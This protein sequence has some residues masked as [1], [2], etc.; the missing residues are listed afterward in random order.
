ML[1]DGTARCGGTGTYGQLGNGTATNTNWISGMVT[2]S[3][4][5]NATKIYT[6]SSGYSTNYG[7]SCAIL[8]DTTIKCWGYNGTG[9]LGDGTTSPKYAPI[10]TTGGTATGMSLAGASASSYNHACEV[11]TD[12]TVKCWGYNGLGQ[13]GDGTTTT[14][15]TPVTVSGITNAVKVYTAI[16]S[17]SSHGRSCALLS[18]TTVKCWGQLPGYGTANTPVT[19]TGLSGVV[20]FSMSQ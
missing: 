9:Q 6:A 7:M 3:G 10:K 12:G 15:P 20:D 18:D 5:T 8:A 11:E 4:L 14:R 13:L 1:A 16:S 17:S 2:V 19:I